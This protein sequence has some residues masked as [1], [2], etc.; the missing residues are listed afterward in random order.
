MWGVKWVQ[1]LEPEGTARALRA[2]L[3]QAAGAG[4]EVPCV[5][6]A[7]LQALAEAAGEPPLLWP[8]EE[9]A[10]GIATRLRHHFAGLGYSRGG[11]GLRSRFLGRPAAVR[12]GM[13]EGWWAGWELWPRERAACCVAGE[14]A[15]AWRRPHS[16]LPL[17]PIDAARQVRSGQVALT[18]A[19]ARPACTQR[20]QRS[21][22]PIPPQLRCVPCQLPAL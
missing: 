3:H 16:R 18:A 1:L 2:L 10:R 4:L 13:C 15:G 6:P 17:G 7:P 14:G 20:L 19:C 5:L 21:H 22:T 8:A 9:L 12:M 11:S